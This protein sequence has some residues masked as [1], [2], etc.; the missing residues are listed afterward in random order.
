MKHTERVPSRGSPER[1]GAEMGGG[2]EKGWWRVEQIVSGEQR[3]DAEELRGERGVEQATGKL[4]GKLVSAA[5]SPEIMSSNLHGH[6]RHRRLKWAARSVDVGPN[7]P[8]LLV[9]LFPL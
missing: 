9:F 5:H 7:C 1:V 2:M 3:Q 4:E 8:Q 6:G